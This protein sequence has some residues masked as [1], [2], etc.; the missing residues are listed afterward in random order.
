MIFKHYASDAMLA[1]DLTDRKPHPHLR[2]HRT[3]W[4]S[5]LNCERLDAARLGTAIFFQALSG[6]RNLSRGGRNQVHLG[7]VPDVASLGFEEV[8]ARGPFLQG[9]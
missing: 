1:Y 9:Y 2:G 7:I 6:C 5:F 4:K 3:I 8:T